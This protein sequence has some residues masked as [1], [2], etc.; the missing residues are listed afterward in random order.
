MDSLDLV[1]IRLVPDKKLLITEFEPDYKS[2]IDQGMILEIIK[3]G[4]APLKDKENSIDIC[5]NTGRA[6]TD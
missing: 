5:E 6:G 3:Q 1:Q 2:F 4:L